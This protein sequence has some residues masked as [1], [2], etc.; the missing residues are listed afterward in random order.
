MIFEKVPL[1]TRTSSNFGALFVKFVILSDE[2]VFVTILGF[3]P[4][5]PLLALLAA[6]FLS[7]RDARQ[8]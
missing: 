5:F 2:L 4:V 1:P 3:F 7:E 8:L 6:D